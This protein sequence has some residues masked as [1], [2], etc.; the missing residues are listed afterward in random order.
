MK[1]PTVYFYLPENDDVYFD[2]PLVLAEG[3]SE[4]GVPFVANRNY[5]RLTPDSAETLFK[6]NPD[7]S[8]ED[9]DIVVIHDDWFYYYPQKT[10]QI[11]M[12]PAPPRLFKNKRQYRLVYLDTWVG[13]ATNSWESEFRECDVILRTQY[14]KN[15]KYPS[16]MRPWVLGYTNRVLKAMSGE[17]LFQQR[18][19]S[20]AENFSYTHPF[21]HGLRQ[22]FLDTVVPLLPP[23]LPIDRTKSHP[24]INNMSE[25]DRLMW[26]QTVDKHNPDY[27]FRLQ[28]S[29]ISATF[30]GFL[31]P[32]L[33]QDASIHFRGEKRNQLLSLAS[34]LMAKVIRKPER[35]IQWDSWRFW[36]TLCAG[37]VALH[38]D[39]EKYG[40]LMPVMPKNWEHYI[41]ID[42]DHVDIFLERLEEERANLERIGKEGHRWALDHYS[43]IQ[44]AR[45]F[46]TEAGYQL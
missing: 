7:V 4:L 24:D 45:R 36:E 3:L 34:R 42:L 8:H 11:Q 20:I 17:T 29:S 37:T 22:I 31:C 41:G 19:Q 16:N 5:W 30:C 1:Y 26:E 18:H 21:P 23:W 38:V 27:F 9:A 39:L 13:A 43:P 28:T 15:C 2:A 33:P 46:L 32:W 12:R 35:L 40:V 25:Y 44:M 14:N 6:H 10:L